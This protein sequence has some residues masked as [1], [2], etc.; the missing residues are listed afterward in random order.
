MKNRTI[1]Y[2]VTRK[3]I[4]DSFKE[5]LVGDLPSP[6]SPSSLNSTIFQQL[7]SLSSPI[8]QFVIVQKYIIDILGEVRKI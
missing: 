5:I 6:L 3:L 1:K 7:S 2:A 8:Q 4:A